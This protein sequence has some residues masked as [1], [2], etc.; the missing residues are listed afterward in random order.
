M[1][2]DFLARVV[3]RTTGNGL[4]R[5]CTLTGRQT[6]ESGLSGPIRCVFIARHVVALTDDEGREISDVSP[7]CRIT[8]QAALAAIGRQPKPLDHVTIDSG[9]HA[10]TYEIEDTEEEDAECT[11]CLLRRA[12]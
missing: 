3:K 4:G 8:H 5:D 6:G 11:G 10:G 2:I 7:Y 9:T 1:G 12:E